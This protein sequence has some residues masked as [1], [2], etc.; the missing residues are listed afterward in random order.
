M[1]YT[2]RESY[3]SGVGDNNTRNVVGGNAPTKITIQGNFGQRI[4]ARGLKVQDG[5][6]RLMEFKELF[7]KSK[8]LTN[9]IKN[10]AP[11]EFRYIYGMNYY[12]FNHKE[13]GSIKLDTLEITS[14]AAVINGVS[15]YIVNF[16]KFG[17]LM[18]SDSKDP[19]VKLAQLGVSTQKKINELNAAIDAKIKSSPILSAANDIIIY[20][21]ALQEA[22]SVVSDMGQNYYSAVAGFNENLLNGD[23]TN[24]G[25]ISSA[26]DTFINFAD[27]L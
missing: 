10:N 8:S 4:I 27:L 3:N 23:I 11:D 21:G 17:E 7:I 13:W 18:S 22:L 16:T 9:V 26:R 19:I 25:F 5:Y 6:G 24:L 20:Y 1:S 15:S 2:G 14:D 12:D